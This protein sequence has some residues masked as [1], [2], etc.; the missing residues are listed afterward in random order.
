MSKKQKRSWLAGQFGLRNLKGI[1]RPQRQRMREFLAADEG[2]ARLAKKFGL[3]SLNNGV[4]PNV[5]ARWLDVGTSK[6]TPAA[7]GRHRTNKLGKF[8]AASAVK[9]LEPNSPEFLAIARCER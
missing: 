4:K 9:T 8:G 6:A 2:N 3:E 5:P 1:K 7:Q